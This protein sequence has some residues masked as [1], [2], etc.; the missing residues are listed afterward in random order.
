MHI[1][2]N[3]TEKSFPEP[4]TV[5]KLLEHLGLDKRKLAVERNREIIPKTEF[6]S[7]NLC[8]GDE[9]EIVHFIGGGTG[10]AQRG[11]NDIDT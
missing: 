6:T 7:I 11:R 9:I 10:R 2:V 1:L 5:E 8:D 4:L 3:G